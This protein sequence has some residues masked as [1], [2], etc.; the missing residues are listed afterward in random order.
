MRVL[1]RVPTTGSCEFAGAAVFQRG[2]DTLSIRLT[3]VPVGFVG[4]F[5][6]LVG[7]PCRRTKT[8][9]AEMPALF[10]ITTGEDW[11]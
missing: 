1:W 11:D 10:G 4:D 8:E 7:V 9:Q 5:Y 6:S 3:I 2:V